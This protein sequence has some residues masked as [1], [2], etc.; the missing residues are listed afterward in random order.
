M[1]KKVTP[2]LVLL[3]MSLF[4]FNCEDDLL[5]PS[6]IELGGA[7]LPYDDSG[8]KKHLNVVTVALDCEL[9][10]E[11]NV[12]NM[13]TMIDRIMTE[14]PGTELIVFGETITGWYYNVMP[15]LSFNVAY[16]F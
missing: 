7:E 9:E 1:I 12:S 2:T 14:K 16:R 10:R 13:E 11:T 5:K 6:F 15:N 8:A 3:L 4:L